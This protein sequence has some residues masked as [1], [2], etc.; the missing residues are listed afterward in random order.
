ME[1]VMNAH[2]FKM[3]FEEYVKA[4]L[5]EERMYGGDYVYEHDMA[6]ILEDAEEA[7]G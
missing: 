2:D 6:E 1:R 4:M 3:P 7:M 5:F